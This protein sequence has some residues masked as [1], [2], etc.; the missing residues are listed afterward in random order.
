MKRKKQKVDTLCHFRSLSPGRCFSTSMRMAWNN[1]RNS[2]KRTEDLRS[3]NDVKWRLSRW[4]FC[5]H[6]INLLP[7]LI[8]PECEGLN[9]F[10][11]V[12]RT[13]SAPNMVYVD[14]NSFHTQASND[15]SD[16]GFQELFAIP[17][18]RTFHGFRQDAVPSEKCIL[19]WNMKPY[20]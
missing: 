10:L 8:A 16:T 14:S 19:R 12:F 11:Q 20:S 1:R 18:H 7:E 17:R 15:W 6:R 9:I 13:L 4:A 5:P 2:L 3:N